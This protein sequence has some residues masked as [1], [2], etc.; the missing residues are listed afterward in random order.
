MTQL[1]R[2]FGAITIAY[3]IMGFPFLA[4]SIPLRVRSLRRRH[5]RAWLRALCECLAVYFSIAAGVVVLQPGPAIAGPS[6]ELNPLAGLGRSSG[7][8]QAALNVIVLAPLGV[9]TGVRTPSVRWAVALSLLVP[10]VIE[11]V[12]FFLPGHRVSSIQDVILGAGGI[13][14]ASAVGRWV[15][16]HQPV[17]QIAAPAPTGRMG[18]PT[19]FHT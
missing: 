6:I 3:L 18:T 4:A 1:N 17:K 9:L 13:L 14:L 15:E 5:A 19:R 11:T 2:L 7:I 10:T 12:Q 16:E 8:M